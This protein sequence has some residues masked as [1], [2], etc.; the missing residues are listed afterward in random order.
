VADLEEAYARAD[1]VVVPLRAG[2]GT[3]IKLLEAMAY[4]V[5][6]IS[7]TLGAEGIDIQSGTH[8]ILVDNPFEFAASCLQLVQDAALRTRLAQNGKALV[9]AAYTEEALIRRIGA[10]G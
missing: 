3:R 1:V 10:L 2:G 8:A 9:K 5:P 6:V 4:G 7:T